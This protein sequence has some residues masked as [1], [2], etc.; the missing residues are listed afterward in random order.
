MLT[1]K[2]TTRRLIPFRFIRSP[3]CFLETVEHS[4]GGTPA[5]KGL[6]TC[7]ELLHPR[8]MERGEGLNALPLSEEGL[9]L[10]AS[11]VE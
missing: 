2:K 1:A 4:T 3:S 7:R 6:Q 5:S 9:E 8:D 10:N 11:R